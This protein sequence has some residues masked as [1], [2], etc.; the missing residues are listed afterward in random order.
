MHRKNGSQWTGSGGVAASEYGM[1][2]SGRKLEWITAQEAP[3]QGDSHEN[4]LQNKE[5]SHENGL[6][7]MQMRAT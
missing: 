1:D 5:K 4:G 3:A 6:K 7:R 2:L